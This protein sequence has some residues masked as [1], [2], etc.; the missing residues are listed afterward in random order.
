MILTFTVIRIGNIAH[1]GAILNTDLG[2]LVM[3]KEQFE[4]EKSYQLTMYIAR[5]MLKNGIITDNEY[6]IIDTNSK[7]KYQPVFGD[8]FSDNTLIKS[9]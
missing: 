7:Q 3:T 6:C 4:R 8:I 5:K 9:E 1:T 2:E